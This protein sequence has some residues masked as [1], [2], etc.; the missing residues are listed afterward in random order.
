MAQLNPHGEELLEQY[1]TRLPQL[2]QLAQRVFTQ[3]S[4]VL[5]GQGLELN[6]IEHRVKTE[7]SLAGKLE[8][9]GDKYHSLED[10]T[11][12]VG[13]RVVTHR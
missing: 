2:Q 12:L 6:S 8:R 11:D 10:I 1:R 9:K 3:L 13:I 7:Q 5:Y 4:E